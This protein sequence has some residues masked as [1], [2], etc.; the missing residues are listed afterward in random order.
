[1]L[2][3]YSQHLKTAL[4]PSQTCCVVR[5]SSPAFSQRGVE[6]GK[7]KGGEGWQEGMPEV[8][9]RPGKQI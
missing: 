7:M 6:V 9:N 4:R 3:L 1:M 2:N 8:G 5:V